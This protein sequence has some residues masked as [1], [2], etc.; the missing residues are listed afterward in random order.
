[1]SSPI[2]NSVLNVSS[3]LSYDPDLGTLSMASNVSGIISVTPGATETGVAITGS[4]VT[5]G[6][7]ETI[8]GLDSM[9]T[10]TGLSIASAA[11]AITGA[12]RL[13]SVAHTGATGTSAILSE[14]ASSAGDETVIAKVTASGA[15][16]LGTALAVASAS[17]TGTALGI[18]STAGTTG[19]SVTVTDSSANT[20]TRSAVTIAV[21]NAAA[22]GATP[23]TLTAANATKPLI[24]GTATVQSTHFYRFATINSVTIYIGDGTTG[25]G[26]LTGV[27]GDLLINGG[28]SKP[29][30]CS[31]S[32][33]TWTALV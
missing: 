2:I 20:G 6:H 27:I 28:S 21:S 33:T 16:A 23:L 13:L 10:G 24:A 17:T 18:T 7:G 26:N 3:P 15:L 32:G 4:S 29:E 12:G 14:F 11:T 5:T 31:T 25:Q 8:L 30:Y 1:M 22:S 19:G 9:T